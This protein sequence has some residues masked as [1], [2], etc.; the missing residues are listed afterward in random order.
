[1]S[2]RWWVLAAGLLALWVSGIA[3]AD[4]EAPYAGA[5][6]YT[7]LYMNVGGEA[8]QEARLDAIE[9]VVQQMSRVLRSTARRRIKAG[10]H[11]TRTYE[12]AVDG[13]QVTITLDDGRC[14]TTPLDG[15]P[16]EFTH[17]GDVMFLSRRWT[18]GTI[19]AQGEQQAGT[20]TYHFR[21]SEDGQTLNV[22]F[23]LDSRHM[24]EPVKFD[25]TYR[26]VR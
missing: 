2:I 1:M 11:V 23:T 9:H 16:V 10:T 14:W 15:T 24:P 26:R 13:D 25:T 18:E 12:I 19:F 8:E 22:A 5:E 20:G 6:R 21:L 4:E 3:L 7:G 17:D